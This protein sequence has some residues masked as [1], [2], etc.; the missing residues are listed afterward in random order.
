MI[1]VE[2]TH[3]LGTMTEWFS[4]TVPQQHKTQLIES[5]LDQGYIVRIV[6][7]G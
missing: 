7:H 2:Y 6:H 5:L 4:E 3:K 1:T